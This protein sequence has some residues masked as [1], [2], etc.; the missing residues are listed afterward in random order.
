MLD[1]NLLRSFVVVAERR[2]LSQA[3]HV[4][5][6]PKSTVSRHV[7]KLEERTGKLFNRLNDGFDLTPV[8]QRLYGQT[9]N[10]IHELSR[11]LFDPG[12]A[13]RAQTLRIQAP[14]NYGRGL[15]NGV[16]AQY[17][18]KNPYCAIDI[19][20]TDRFTSPDLTAVDLGVF[21][22]IAPGKDVEHWPAGFVEAKLY[23]APSLF[24]K[25]RRPKTPGDLKNWP[26]VT[27]DCVPGELGRIRLH[28]A[29]EKR[30]L[31]GQVRLSSA[32]PEVLLTAAIAGIGIARLPTFYADA[33]VA[34]GTLVAVL[35][36][37][38]IDRHAVTLGR[39]R[40]NKN[41][42]AADFAEFAVATLSR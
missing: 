22:G 26:V 29:R 23:A 1:L 20:L 39:S 16:I 2:R 25:A 6:L 27:N 36:D 18:K 34:A 28:G 30:A 13:E 24:R 21:V 11:E 41:V 7:A 33:A 40:L 14:A 10:A 35:P 38:A 3:A 17:L 32:E 4:L 8:G 31:L 12:A 19:T 9:K 37:Y 42:A 5:G 15:L